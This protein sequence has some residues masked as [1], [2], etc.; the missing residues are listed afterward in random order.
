MSA[1]RNVRISA[2]ATGGVAWLELVSSVTTLES[3]TMPAPTL[4]YRRLLPLLL[5]FSELNQLRRRLRVA[6]P[7]QDLP[8]SL[9]DVRRSP[10]G[11]SELPPASTVLT[12]RDD[13]ST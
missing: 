1:N 5:P 12:G 9:R 6:R 10:S 7:Q 4:E 8:A 13:S 2:P 11:V 3:T